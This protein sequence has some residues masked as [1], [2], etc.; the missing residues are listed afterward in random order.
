VT[1]S[2]T[3]QALA[4]QVVGPLAS[5][6]LTAELLAAL[7]QCRAVIQ[8]HCDPAKRVS[9]DGGKTVFSALDA[10]NAA[11]AVINKARGH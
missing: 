2:A 7:D 4:E 9:I 10:F 8:C 11:V 3:I 5:D 6:E 1:A